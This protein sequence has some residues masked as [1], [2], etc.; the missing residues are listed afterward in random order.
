MVNSL[1]EWLTPL[2]DQKTLTETKKTLWENAKTTLAEKEALVVTA[3]ANWDNRNAAD[4]GQETN[5]NL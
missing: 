2:N 3:Q 5:N 4:D 1:N